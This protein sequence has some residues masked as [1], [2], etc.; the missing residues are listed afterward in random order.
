MQGLF[1]SFPFIIYNTDIT[2]NK[3]Y[4]VIIDLYYGQKIVNIRLVNYIIIEQ[5]V[6]C[7]NN[8]LLVVL[9]IFTSSFL[10]IMQ[11]NILIFKPI[12]IINLFN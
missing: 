6:T 1:N 8:W 10:S 4:K 3:K 5:T 7:V 11:I 9:I 12:I 2:N